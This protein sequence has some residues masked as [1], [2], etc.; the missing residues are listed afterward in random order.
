VHGNHV[1]YQD[2]S[3]KGKSEEVD[4]HAASRI[5]EH[6]PDRVALGLLEAQ[7]VWLSTHDCVK[8]RRVLLALLASLDE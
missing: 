4:P 3:A 6:E 5:L 7:G 1:N 2:V 8:L